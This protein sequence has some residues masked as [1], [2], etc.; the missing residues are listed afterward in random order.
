VRARAFAA[1]PSGLAN[2]VLS[3]QQSLFVRPAL[4]STLN[5]LRSLDEKGYRREIQKLWDHSDLRPHI[6]QLLIAFLGSQ[7]TPLPT[8]VTYFRNALE[9][10]EWRN[11]AFDELRKNP[12]WFSSVRPTLAGLMTKSEALAGKAAWA[13]I[14][15]VKEHRDGVLSLIQEYWAPA[16]EWD[17]YILHALRELDDWNEWAVNLVE[18]SVRRSSLNGM[19]VRMV[20]EGVAKSAPNLAPRLISAGLWRE[21]ERIEAEP[22][23]AQPPPDDDADEADHVSYLL[24]ERPYDAVER[25]VSRSE[26]WYGIERIVRAAPRAFVDQVWPWFLQV[27]EK[28]AAGVREGVRSYRA[29]PVFRLPGDW[30][31]DDHTLTAALDLA[32]SEFAK[33]CPQDFGRFLDVHGNSDFLSAHRMLAR[34][35]SQI[36]ESHASIALDYMLGDDRRLGL[37]K[38][39]S[40]HT[41][42]INLIR[43]VSP[44]LPDSELARLENRVREAVK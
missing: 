8:E 21:W 24:R 33:G 32:L 28:H 29:D 38:D 14:E 10:P 26:H 31:V 7:A 36:A 39:V 12:P 35:L 13:L 16:P 11:W 44:H 9:N 20:A 15:V 23:P 42:S 18:R 2:H 19:L 22:V 41:E 34:A 40:H 37:G 43:S 4:W 17:P 1:K 6:R 5:Y 3:K 25:F 30:S 27:A